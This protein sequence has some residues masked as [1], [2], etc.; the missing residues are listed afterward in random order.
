MCYTLTTINKTVYILFKKKKRDDLALKMSAQGFRQQPEEEPQLRQQKQ[1]SGCKHCGTETELVRKLCGCEK[2][3]K[4]VCKNCFLLNV[5]E[6]WVQDEKRNCIRHKICKKRLQLR[7]QTELLPLVAAG[8]IAMYIIKACDWTELILQQFI[9][10]YL[11]SIKINSIIIILLFFFTYRNNLCFSSWY[12]ILFNLILIQLA[13]IKFD[14]IVL[15]FRVYLPQI[16]VIFLTAISSQLFNSCS[17]SYYNRI[18]SSSLMNVICFFCLWKFIYV[19]SPWFWIWYLYCFNPCLIGRVSTLQLLNPKILISSSTHY[20][21][22]CTIDNFQ[23]QLNII[24]YLIE[25]V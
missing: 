8:F 1:K 13:I 14:L 12:R 23:A 19:S 16:F 20:Y 2:V 7:S 4:Y 18:I 9:E 6:D 10:T 5:S 21:V 11:F 17:Y 25:K 22:N 24:N 3:K 15:F